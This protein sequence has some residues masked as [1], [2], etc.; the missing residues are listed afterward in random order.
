MKIDGTLPCPFCGGE[1][2]SFEYPVGIHCEGCGAHGPVKYL[3]EQPRA[4]WNRRLNK[5]VRSLSAAAPCVI[6]EGVTEDHCPDCMAALCLGSE[7]DQKHAT[8]CEPIQRA[9]RTVS[10]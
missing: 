3:T 5:P 1:D 4:A 8:S 9:L 6:C 10:T 2:L 7:C